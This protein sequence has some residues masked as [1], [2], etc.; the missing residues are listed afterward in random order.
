[1]HVKLSPKNLSFYAKKENFLVLM[2]TILREPNRVT[3]S[4]GVYMNFH[5]HRHHRSF[6]HKTTQTIKIYIFLSTRILIGKN[7][8][9]CKVGWAFYFS[10]FYHHPLDFFYCY[11]YG[12]F[13]KFYSSMRAFSLIDKEWFSRAIFLA[14]KGEE[15]A[16]KIYVAFF[17][18]I[19]VAS[20][21]FNIIKITKLKSSEILYRSQHQHH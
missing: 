7:R 1:M 19:F 3:I 17:Y 5:H 18:G 6:Q 9:H 12:A 2:S 13:T 16:I 15:F 21:L 14:K 20:T 11:C 10:I 8:K 4:D